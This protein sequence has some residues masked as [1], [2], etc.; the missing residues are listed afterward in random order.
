MPLRPVA[1]AL[2]TAVALAVATAAP[3]PATADPTTSVPGTSAVSTAAVTDSAGGTFQQV[4][5]FGANPGKLAMYTYTPAGLP[6]GAPLVVALHGCVQSAN[7]YYRNSGWTKFADQYGFAVVFPQTGSANNSLSCF[8]W[9]DAGKDAR[10]VGEA[11]SVAEMVAKAKA[12]YGS[13]AR[14]V[15]VTG[16]S[17][18]GGMA[19]DLLADSPTCSPAGRSTPGCPPTAPPPRVPPPAVRTPTRGSP[20]RSGATRSEPR[21]RATPGR[22]PGWRS[23]RA[24]P[25]PPSGR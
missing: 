2:L 17:A 7:D 16:L 12:L 4:T 1:A 8:S 20:R 25:T 19:A 24:A 23:G 21:I 5:G 15:F 9:F 6:G 22:G 10:G 14:R 18:G 13:D 11:E 3:A